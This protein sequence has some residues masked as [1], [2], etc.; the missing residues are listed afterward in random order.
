[1]KGIDIRHDS[2]IRAHYK[3]NDKELIWLDRFGDDHARA[4]MIL[5]LLKSSWTHGLNPETYNVSMLE[6]MLQSHGSHERLG[7]DIMLTDALLNYAQDLTGFRVDPT[8]VRQKADYWRMAA[9]PKDIFQHLL[10]ADDL[11][12]AVDALAPQSALYEQMRE[13]LITLGQRP[14]EASEPFQLEGILRPGDGHKKVA[15]VRERMGI[16]EA[17]RGPYY[18]D[19]DLALAVMELQRKN[20][21]KPDGIIG[22]KTVSLMNRTKEDMIRQLVVNLE[23]MRWLERDKPEKYVLVNVPSATLWAVENGAVKLEMPVIVGRKGRET[24]SFKT[25]ITGVRVNPNWTVPPTIKRRDFLPRLKEDP[26][27]LTENGIEFIRGYGS[28]AETLDP[29]S[30]D[31]Q[32]LSWPELN[33]IRMV[34]GPGP[35]NPLGRV[36]VIMPNI[37]NIYLHDTNTPEYFS[38]STRALSS[39]CVRVKNPEALAHFIMKGQRGWNN[40]YFQ[41][42]LDRGEMVDV[43]T[44][45]KIPVYLMYQTIWLDDQ[46]K[47]VFGP[48]I[49]ND[50]EDLFEVLESHQHVAQA[51]EIRKWASAYQARLEKLAQSETDLAPVIQTP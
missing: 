51:T 34:Q 49:Y 47:M 30:I 22:S 13:E 23:R 9:D 36:R 5:S 21:L 42:L 39:G 8:L 50:D 25:E 1:M 19:D 7:L 31:W 48:D 2:V 33:K 12:K 41:Y 15:E 40:A 26:Y 32:N 24:R 44:S 16:Q 11:E 14:E 37:Y 17:P 46:G 28:K 10:K 45:N 20:G 35:D 38:R 18:Y 6:A 27:A 3:D 29:A 43:K 4:N